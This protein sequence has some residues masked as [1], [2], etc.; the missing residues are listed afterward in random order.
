GLHGEL[1]HLHATQPKSRP[2]LRKARGCKRR[3][4]WVYAA[5]LG[6][7][8]AHGG[9]LLRTE[10]LRSLDL[11][12]LA[13]EAL[14]QEGEDAADASVQ[15]SVLRP[16]GVLRVAYDAPF[17]YGRRGA[18]WYRDHHAF[19]RV[20]S[21]RTSGTVHAYAIDADAFEAVSSYA[22]GRRVG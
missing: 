5:P 20:A 18:R 1:V 4:A 22:A 17:T 21:A 15:V 11:V 2:D 12:A 9:Y 16:P 19:A 13:R 3:R 10:D 6:G 14:A 7:V 8:S